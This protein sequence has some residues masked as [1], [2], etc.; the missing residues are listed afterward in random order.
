MSIRSQPAAPLR[1]AVSLPGD[2]SIS[3][4][5][6]LMAAMAAG[7]S[8]IDGML[9]AGVTQV[10]LNALTGLRIEWSWEGEALVVEGAGR[11][12]FQSPSAEGA[13]EAKPLNCGNSATTMRLLSGALAGKPGWISNSIR[14][15]FIL[16]G[17]EQLQKRPMNRV[18][19]PLCEMGAEIRSI[20]GTGCAPLALRQSPLKGIE[21]R[22]PVAS[23]QVKSAVLLAGLSASGSTLVEE[24]SPSRDHTERLFSWLG[25][26]VEAGQCRARVFPLQEPL[27]PLTFKVPGDFSS[28]AFLLAAAAIVPGSDVLV[29]GVGLNPRRTGLLAVLRRMGAEI[30]AEAQT[31]SAGEPVGDLRVRARPLKGTVVE[32]GEVVDM[33]DEFPV[34]AVAAACAEGITEVRHAAELRHKESD[35]ISVLAG[36]LRKLGI[37]IAE[38]PDGFSIRGPVKFPGGI[39]DG[40]GDHR[41]AMS[42]AVAGMVSQNAVAVEGPECIAESFPGFAR[43]FNSLGARLE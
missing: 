24:P 13:G 9:R 10:M 34:L 3:H 31:E 12:G 41:L 19:G 30:T 1:G 14:P 32:G 22:T 20:E 15:E 29:Q 25:V 36:E 38:S 16:D 40:H 11:R 33:I 6:A 21:Y 37:D 43:L 8:R 42:L 28:A 17:S 7:R 18:I 27:P 2:K 39:A 5:A 35:R 26:R 23:A 4:R